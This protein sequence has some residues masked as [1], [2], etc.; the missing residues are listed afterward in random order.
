MVELVI[1]RTSSSTGSASKAST[2]PSSPL[3]AGTT[4]TLTTARTSFQTVIGTRWL[5]SAL[6]GS[7][8]STLRRS[9]RSLRAFQI[10]SATSERCG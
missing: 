2:M 5:P 9:T 8:S 7:S 4:I 10:A 6:I 1:Y 3:A